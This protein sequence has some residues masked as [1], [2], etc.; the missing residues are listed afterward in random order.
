MFTQERIYNSGQDGIPDT[1]DQLELRFWI[2]NDVSFTENY[3]ISPGPKKM[4]CT[5][6]IWFTSSMPLCCNRGVRHT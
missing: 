5:V 3:R 2:D 6:I 4:E 1:L